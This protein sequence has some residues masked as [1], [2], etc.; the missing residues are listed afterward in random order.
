MIFLSV[1][2]LQGKSVCSLKKDFGTCLTQGI[3]FYHDFDAGA[4]K[5]FVYSGCGGNG[6]NFLSGEDCVRTCGGLLEVAG[7]KAPKLPEVNPQTSTAGTTSTT[8]AAPT[9][10]TVATGTKTSISVFQRLQQNNYEDDRNSIED[11]QES[12]NRFAPPPTG[13]RIRVRVRQ[14][15]RPEQTGVDIM[16]MMHLNV[17][18]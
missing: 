9:T 16:I 12:D 14:R 2:P 18:Q 15:K 13:S 17:C 3:R 1:V 8:T 6:N 10:T 4:C 5:K 7:N 11:S